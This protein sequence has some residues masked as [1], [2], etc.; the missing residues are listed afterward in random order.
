VSD[1]VIRGKGIEKNLGQ[2]IL[3]GELVT[4]V[5]IQIR[6]I[7]NGVFIRGGI[8]IGNAYITERR[9][10]GPAYQDAY[11]LES[12]VAQ[13][14]RIV[15]SNE[16]V[17]TFESN[18]RL[19]GGS[20]DG[21]SVEELRQLITK[22]DDGVWFLD[23][24]RAS[25]SECDD[26]F[27][28]LTFIARHRDLIRENLKKFADYPSVLPKYEWLKSYHNDFVAGLNSELLEQFGTTKS[29]LEVSA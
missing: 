23:Y 5:I 3:Q 20:D 15:L 4:L 12:K 24:L 28:Y 18:E 19:L 11:E 16:V 21:Q 14:P 9:F 26:E 29:A 17:E 25:E 6:L 13:F 10:F 1:A 7:H 22:R 8:S 2:A 27:Q